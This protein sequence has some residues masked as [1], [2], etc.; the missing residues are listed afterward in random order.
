MKGFHR[1]TEG[2]DAGAGL[3]MAWHKG[4]MGASDRAMRWGPVGS[5]GTPGSV[6]PA[7][8]VG[9]EKKWAQGVFGGTVHGSAKQH[10]P[11]TALTVGMEVIPG[12]T[13]LPPPSNHKRRNPRRGPT[14]SRLCPSVAPPPKNGPPGRPAATRWLRKK[15]FLKMYHYHCPN[16]IYHCRKW[17]L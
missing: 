4:N 12:A 11:G 10:S 9:T 7:T 6:K 8:A 15:Q 2:R 16:N 14:G 17:S 5:H 13:V 1:H 3:H